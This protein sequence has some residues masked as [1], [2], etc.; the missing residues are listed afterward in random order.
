M[1]NV[2]KIVIAACLALVVPFPCFAV[3]KAVDDELMAESLTGEFHKAPPEDKLPA[4]TETKHQEHKPPGKNEIQIKGLWIGMDESEI[5]EKFGAPIK[6]F[7]IAGVEG[8]YST[9]PLEFENNKLESLIFFFDAKSFDDVLAAVKS[10]Y[11]E[12]QCKDSSVG[13][14]MGASFTQVKCNLRRGKVTLD[15]SR[16][17]NDITTSSLCLYSD[18][19]MKKISNKLKGKLKD[20]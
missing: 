13:N 2:S 4:S 20:I 7:S 3:T 11:P 9:T 12:M 1:K 18:N 5:E 17:V 6:A 15:L 14:A 19:Y 16:F 8:K 10:K